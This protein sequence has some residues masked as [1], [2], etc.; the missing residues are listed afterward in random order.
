MTALV[1]TIAKL[2]VVA[3]D[4]IAVGSTEMLWTVTLVTVTPKTCGSWQWQCEVGMNYNDSLTVTACVPE[5]DCDCDT[6]TQS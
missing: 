5:C 3:K 1:L 2:V 6:V 4:S